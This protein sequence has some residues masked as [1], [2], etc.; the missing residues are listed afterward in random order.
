MYFKQLFTELNNKQKEFDDVETEIVF[1][2]DGDNKKSI[3]KE[4]FNALSSESDL[5]KDLDAKI[6]IKS[7]FDTLFDGEKF[8]SSIVHENTSKQYCV[9]KKPIRKMKKIFIDSHYILS[10]M[11]VINSKREQE[12]KNNP[13]SLQSFR[14]L[15]RITFN[16][17]YGFKIDFSASL[18]VRK[19]Q[20]EQNAGKVNMGSVLKTYSKYFT[21]TMN[22]KK[23]DLTTLFATDT[24]TI[25]NLKS[26]VKNASTKT[27][28]NINYEAEIE[29]TESDPENIDFEK[30]REISTI[31]Y[32]NLDIETKVLNDHIHKY[33]TK[34][35][36]P[37]KSIN[38]QPIQVSKKIYHEILL[39]HNK[40]VRG[41]GYAITY[42]K[43]GQR[44]NIWIDAFSNIITAYGDDIDIYYSPWSGK[45]IIGDIMFDAEMIDKQ[46]IIFDIS[47]DT[48]KLTTEVSLKD[49][50]AKI[51]EYVK[52]LS[53]SDFGQKFTIECAN[54][55]FSSDKK[56]LNSQIKMMW[57]KSK[58]DNL[59]F[60][61]D[62]LVFTSFDGY[63]NRIFKW[64]PSEH[65][66]VDFMVNFMS[67]KKNEF[68]YN[69][70][71]TIK[72]ENITN[73]TQ[74][75][76]FDEFPGSQFT[77]FGDSFGKR[78]VTTTS[79]LKNHS[80][81][82]MLWH[83]TKQKWSIVRH[84]P[85][86]YAN[87]FS[88]AT[89][90]FQLINDPIDID[91]LI[92]MNKIY[93]S[94]TTDVSYG[95]N[96]ERMK[97]FHSWVR[98]Q[99]YANYLSGNIVNDDQPKA[100]LDIGSGQGGEVHRWFLHKF[101]IIIGIEPAKSS[102]QTAT[103][104]FSDKNKQLT[105]GQPAIFK[106]L[107][108]DYATFLK[109]KKYKKLIKSEFRFGYITAMFSIQFHLTSKAKYNELFKTAYKML[110]KGGIFVILTF[111]GKNVIDTFER[112]KKQYKRDY[113]GHIA[114]D[115]D[116]DTYIVEPVKIDKKNIP[117]SI[118]RVSS[119]N[120]SMPREEHLVDFDLL[121]ISAKNNGFKHLETMN[122]EQL[123]KR[124]YIISNQASRL[125]LSDAFKTISFMNNAVIYKK[126]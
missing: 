103:N 114:S 14:L 22:G 80:T 111:N 23:S 107:N 3:Y 45:G 59:P 17:P 95:D 33:A 1:K 109:S 101:K 34:N 82:E 113:I 13:K 70:Y 65:L 72:H 74:T 124:K 85:G 89:S 56:P 5:I 27:V 53:K 8:I 10:N 47:I 87:L 75:F 120:L 26:I 19:N 36:I 29:F 102:I 62:G 43:D 46:V 39:T 90:M 67:S 104:R 18:T 15:F 32:Q 91:D 30:L 86:K 48:G 20:L 16:T 37:F 57:K 11:I 99:I 31:I 100:I 25:K 117:K 4:I 58:I 77:K 7:Y 81:Y 112:I 96:I 88:I 119:S 122:F 84:R 51:K 12:F 83:P 9:N 125:K 40:P 54:F 98:Y 93:K 64:K 126:I 69:L 79:E 28:N 116:M 52:L 73:T 123:Y 35:N 108:M 115:V 55:V 2:I 6:M 78:T 66:T 61:I 105:D 21:D 44:L 42:K 118:I 60:K 76:R 63:S 38:N 92:G 97:K 41:R 50:I 49:R 106:Q 94:D 68:V 110:L 71:S 24:L 121:N